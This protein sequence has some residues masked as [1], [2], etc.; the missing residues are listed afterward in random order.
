MS[1]DRIGIHIGSFTVHFYGVIIMLGVLAATI[2]GTRRAKNDGE[3][4]ERGWDMLA[5]L[6]IAGVIGARI[7]HILTPPASMVEQGITFQYYMTH[8]LDALAIWNGGLGIPGAVAGGALALFIYARRNGLNFLKWAD[9]IVPGLALAQAIGRLGNFVNQELYGLPSNL[10]W[11]IYIEPRFRIPE[12][13]NVE[14][15][16]PLFLY[17]A[18]W[19]LATM[20]LLIWLDKKLKKYLKPGDLLLGY[21]VCYP[22]GRFLLEFLRLDPSPV[23]GININQTSM[24][25]IALASAAGLAW[26]HRELFSRTKTLNEP[27][28]SEELETP[29]EVPESEEGTVSAEN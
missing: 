4:P 10:P 15:Y 3:D 24:A 26:R 6:V 21:L 28:I 29:V 9:Y 2:V 23:A 8:P 14:R 7:W 18:L 25:V 19:N 27:K 1:I 22:V 16:H 20:A 17:E 11:A 12:Y 5:W 13:M